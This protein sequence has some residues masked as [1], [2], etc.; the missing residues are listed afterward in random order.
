MR[1][2]MSTPS[3]EFAGIELLTPCPGCSAPMPVNTLIE[4]CR[5][6]SCLSESALPAFVWEE[7]LGGVERDV[8]Q[9]GAGYL[10]H[11]PAWGESG[12]PAGPHVAWLRGRDAPPC[13]RCQQPMRLWPQG[14]C[15][16]GACGAVRTVHPRPPW[17]K[18][19][20]P[21]IGYVSDEPAVPEERPREPVQVAC[22]QCGGPLVA[23]GSSRIVPC[24]YCAARVALPDA[25]WAALHP[26][27]AKKRWWL[28]VRV[29]KDPRRGPANFNRFSNASTMLGGSM[30]L[31]GTIVLVFLAPAVYET[32]ELAIL[33]CLI[34][35]LSVAAL[36]RLRAHWQYKRI[37]RPE[38]EVTGRLHRSPDSIH[39]IEVRITPPN[40]PANVLASTRIWHLSNERFVE[41]GGEGG[42][43]RAWIIPQKPRSF[44]IDLVPS[45]LE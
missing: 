38:H 45:I 42:K 19:E 20:S 14:A 44:H 36:L 28:A 34:A 5:C 22:T 40:Q 8:V 37:C 1:D 30:I 32:P 13:P 24:G 4:R 6:S 15:V 16:C 39:D 18:A 29:D 35:P 10:R 23:D 3:F 11:G 41:L 9:F 26:P 31:L 33:P 17:L 25:V 27:R 7:A 12:T 43:I 2:T 21:V